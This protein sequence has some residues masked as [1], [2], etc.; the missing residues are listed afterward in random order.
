MTELIKTM[1]STD[2]P[3]W[4]DPE[5]LIR[6]VLLDVAS[7]GTEVP[8]DPSGTYSWLPFLRVQCFGGGEIDPATDLFRFDLDAFAATKAA[9]SQLAG[10]ARQRLLNWPVVTDKGVLDRVTTS[11]RPYQMAYGDESYVIRYTAQYA[12]RMRRTS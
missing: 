4:P 7:V 5:I 11:T 6:A 2:L 8:A 9:A 10:R 3:D 1:E 12:G